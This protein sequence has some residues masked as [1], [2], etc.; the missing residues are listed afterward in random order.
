MRQRALFHWTEVCFYDPTLSGTTSPDSFPIKVN[1]RRKAMKDYT[2]SDGNLHI[3][4]G[5]TVCVS[6]YNASH[7]PDTYPDPET[8]DGRRFVDGNHKDTTKK[9][10]DV[11]E[12]YLIW[13]YGSLAWYDLKT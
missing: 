2:F 3:P 5:E 10:S 9:Y 7:N 6:S 1:V 11:S 12:Q 13:G 8:F 4:A